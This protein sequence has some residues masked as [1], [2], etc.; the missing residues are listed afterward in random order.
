MTIRC[1]VHCR[2]GTSE[3]RNA[4]ETVENERKSNTGTL[5]QLVTMSVHICE[6]I[7][8]V[9]VFQIHHP[10]IF[11]PFIF[12]VNVSINFFS[13][14]SFVFRLSGRRKLSVSSIFSFVVSKQVA[15]TSSFLRIFAAVVVCS[16][17]SQTICRLKFIFMSFL[18]GGM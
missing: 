12:S 17:Q 8:L 18:L 5:H 10:H 9:F 6:S 3:K 4:I 11:H 7:R 16:L 15:T 14:T 2:F 1:P 13:F